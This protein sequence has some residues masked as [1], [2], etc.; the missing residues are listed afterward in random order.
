MR[1]Q[2]Y[3]GF[4]PFTRA[5]TYQRERKRDTNI[6]DPKT[7]ADQL[8]LSIRFTGQAEQKKMMRVVR[9]DNPIAFRQFC[10]ENGGPDSILDEEG[11]TALSLSAKLGSNRVLK[12][13]LR[14]DADAT[15]QNH[16]GDNALIHASSTDHGN[17]VLLLLK[18]L[19]QRNDFM[20]QLNQVNQDGNTAIMVAGKSGS[21]A[22]VELLKNYGAYLHH[23][24]TQDQNLY[25]L[26]VIGNH[27]EIAKQYEHI[28]G[29]KPIVTASP[30]DSVSQTTSPQ[31]VTPSRFVMQHYTD[32]QPL[33]NADEHLEKYLTPK[34]AEYMAIRIKDD[35]EAGD[36][37]KTLKTK[38]RLATQYHKDAP[39]KVRDFWDKVAQIAV[40]KS[41]NGI[42]RPSAKG[43]AAVAGMNDVKEQIETQFLLPYRYKLNPDAYRKAD[44]SLP[45]ASAE[46]EFGLLLYGLPGTGKTYIAEKMVE[47]LDRPF[48]NLRFSKIG[49]SMF[50]ETEQ[51]ITGAFEKAA[52]AEKKP[53]FVIINEVDTFLNAKSNGGKGSDH[54]RLVN[55]LLEELD[56]APKKEVSVIA[57]VNDKDSLEAAGIRKGRFAAEIPVPPPDKKARHALFDMY[58]PLSNTARRLPFTEEDRKIFAEK[59]RGF[60]AAGVESLC[61]QLGKHCVDKR[62]DIHPDVML[63][64]IAKEKPSY[65]EAQLAEYKNLD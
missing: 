8:S 65:T 44:G 23:R 58:L 64:L 17:A 46:P 32:E 12:E 56:K 26:A 52:K 57:T 9:D 14:Q 37:V 36:T 31:G 45:D 28:A 60:S 35:L 40:G 54:S 25:W 41:V 42:L 11:N 62:M 33:Y 1:I 24:N 21:G 59:G 22:I 10:Q 61:K 2:S 16:H 39:D 55:T 6:A 43:F 18:Q 51:A 13:A 20:N 38:V 48:V 49:S 4:Q 7:A 34:I 15:K 47:E 50:S 19:K 29:S 3:T 53:A 5:N 27:Q 63:E 30:L